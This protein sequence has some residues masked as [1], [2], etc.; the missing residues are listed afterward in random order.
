M[1]FGEKDQIKDELSGLGDASSSSGSGALGYEAG[2]SPAAGI[3]DDIEKNLL[4]KTMPRKFKVSVPNQERTK[5][6]TVGALIMIIGLVVMGAAVYLVYAFL[7]NPQK[8]QV[9][10]P[11]KQAPAVTPPVKEVVTPAKE[12]VKED[13][14]ATT[15][16]TSVPLGG[17]SVVATT[18]PVATST[19]IVPVVATSSPSV[20]TTTPSVP[21][22]IPSSAADKDGDGLSDAEEALFGTK[23]DSVDS[24]GDGFSDKAELG[25]LYNPAGQGKLEASPYISKYSDT[26]NGYS[27]LYPSVWRAQKAGDSMIFSSPDNSFVQVVFEPNAEKKGVLAW[28][29][30]QF[31]EK[32]LSL[33]DIIIKNGWEGLYHDDRKIFYLTPAAKN[34]IITISYVPAE[35]GNMAYY[36]I[37]QTLIDS[38][39]LE[40]K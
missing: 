37:F 34:S 27:V 9:Q 12:E 6:K 16:G 7:I 20:A 19:P 30:D 3:D 4:I 15:T 28:Y 32:P 40:G 35:E 18:T 38:F 11:Q 21:S 23:S 31:S 29:N 36:G 8:N 17:G 33:S 13:K 22:V 1:A 25:N 26:A 2:P 39:S 24:D 14:K 5:T 10:I